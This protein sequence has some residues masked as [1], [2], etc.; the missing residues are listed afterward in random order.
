[1]LLAKK[2]CNIIYFIIKYFTNNYSFLQFSNKN[3]VIKIDYSYEN[4]EFIFLENNI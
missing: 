2:L 1:M 4:Y 3:F